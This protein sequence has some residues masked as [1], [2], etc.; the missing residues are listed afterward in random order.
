MAFLLRQAE[1]AVRTTADRTLAE[2]QLTLS[3][4]FVL[5]LVRAAR[6]S[7][8]AALARRYAVAPRAMTGLLAGLE[9]AGLVSRNDHPSHRRIKLISLTPEGVRRTAAAEVLVDAL[10]S[11]LAPSVGARTIKAWLK[12]TRG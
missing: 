4:Y 2:T 10:E 7:S 5:R 3:Q 1:A 9:S 11:D 6:E 12:Q 8:S